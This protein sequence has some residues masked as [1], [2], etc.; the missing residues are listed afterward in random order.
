MAWA[1][2]AAYRLGEREGSISRDEA[3][4]LTREGVVPLVR[5]LPGFIDFELVEAGDTFLA[6]SHWRTKAEAEGA[7][8]THETW[9]QGSAPHVP[10]PVAIYVGEVVLSREG[11]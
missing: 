11:Q 3:V 1:R 8:G 7:H 6:I 10:R 4:E 9:R 2:I 5:E